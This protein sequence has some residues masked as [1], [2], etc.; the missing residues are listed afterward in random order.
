MTD[1]YRINPKIPQDPDTIWAVAKKL[2][3][4]RKRDEFLIRPRYVYSGKN[5]RIAYPGFLTWL[6]FVD[7]DR[8]G[9]DLGRKV[10][11]YDRAKSRYE[12]QMTQLLKE[13]RE[14]KDGKKFAA[15]AII[16]DQ[17]DRPG[18]MLITFQPSHWNEVTDPSTMTQD[19]AAARGKIN[20]G[21]L[22]AGSPSSIRMSPEALTDSVGFGFM[23][24][25][26]VMLHEMVHAVFEMHGKDTSEKVNRGWWFD[27]EFFAIAVENVFRSEKGIRQMRASHADDGSFIDDTENLLDMVK[28]QPP[29][30]MLFARFA[31]L[32]PEVFRQL[33][34]IP[35]SKAKFNPFRDYKEEQDKRGPTDE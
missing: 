21:F 29:P 10:I 20:Q 15:P 32:E 18:G 17:V 16:I 12:L 34:L 26:M 5:I 22:V 33:A 13:F 25:D 14:G 35:P 27:N 7:P 19:A 24:A 23:T 11:A 6:K 2:L 9:E 4:G 8:R 1:P 31:R 28:I 30:R 3:P